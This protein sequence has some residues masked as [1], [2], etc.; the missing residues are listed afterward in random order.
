MRIITIGM[1][2]IPILL[3][4][5]C[6][7]EE[8]AEEAKQWYKP[9]FVTPAETNDD[10]LE[11]GFGSEAMATLDEAAPAGLAV[12][13]GAMAAEE[14]RV[15]EGPIL[16]EGDGA[17]AEARVVTITVRRG[18]TIRLYARWSG[19]KQADMRDANDMG[20]KGGLKINQ[21]FRLEL[22]P[23]QYRS[24]TE[25][26]TDHFNQLEKE[27]FSRFEVVGVDR[28]VVRPGDNVWRISKL[29]GKVPPW[30]LEKF[31]SNLNLAK[32]KVGEE[33]VIPILGEL[34]AS[35]SSAA[36]ELFAKADA[37][38]TPGAAT[39][40]KSAAA[41][42]KADVK[43]SARARAQ[44]REEATQGITIKVGRGETLGH[45]CKWAGV[46]LKA[47]LI[48]NPG[49]D[50]NLIRLGQ[51]V[52]LPIPDGRMTAFYR[53]RR[54]FNG[55]P[56]PAQLRPAEAVAKVSKP[57]KAKAKAKAK[58]AKAKVADTQAADA[59]KPTHDGDAVVAVKPIKKPKAVA[60]SKP[61][62]KAKAKAKRS[63]SSWKQ[64]KVAAGETAWTIAVQR[65]KISLRS[66]RTANPG[67]NLDRLRVGEVL[68]IPLPQNKPGGSSARRAP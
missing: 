34:A 17:T 11:P 68:T 5:A 33:L 39:G 16:V 26:R 9:W 30:V 63:G 57:A 35:D 48:A 37:G 58:A 50:K 62:P 20:K 52:R 19:L 60:S 28:Y 4:T 64:H 54:R 6:G 42:A 18:E 32:L 27:F 59:Q 53:K 7:D 31:N 45:Y 49:M 21:A 23:K 66:L 65:Y 40:Q 22:T 10:D 47:V 46:S 12:G 15:A 43:S 13:D 36:D 24:F 3:L 14:T 25:A 41:K 8:A 56:P 1:V 61:K 51:K 67:K 29:H 38:N 55:T 44:A 2:I